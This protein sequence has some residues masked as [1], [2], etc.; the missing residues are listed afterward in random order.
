M[1]SGK[2]TL[3]Q[4]LIDDH[5]FEKLS[6]A[7]PLKAMTM[8]FF[9]ECGFGEY[10]AKRLTYGTIADKEERIEEIGTTSRWIQQSLG[11]EWGR[12]LI[13]P[14]IWVQLTRLKAKALLD[15]GKSV[16]I[17]D[18][19]F[20]NELEMVQ[21][22][23]WHPVRINRPGAVVTT[24]GHASEGALDGYQMISLQNDGDLD[25]LRNYATTLATCPLR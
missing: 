7:G 9:R 3:A 22:E 11:T 15:A 12:N 8:A 21:E 4:F 18:M 19:R 2:S 17:D 24:V 16:V 1:G 5:G 14:D 13:R 6:F 10:E 23:G 25:H 20:V